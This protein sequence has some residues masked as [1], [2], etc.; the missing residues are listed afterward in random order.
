MKTLFYIE[1]LDL[2]VIKTGGFN[3][4]LLYLH[5]QFCMNDKFPTDSG[6]GGNQYNKNQQLPASAWARWADGLNQR[7]VNQQTKV[8]PGFARNSS[9]PLHSARVI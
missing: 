7:I 4:L 9:H 5:K 2:H 8:V 3:G 6:E 1:A